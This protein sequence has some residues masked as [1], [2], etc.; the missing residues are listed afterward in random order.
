MPAVSGQGLGGWVLAPRLLPTLSTL[1]AAIES[2]AKH[3]KTRE[4]RGTMMVGDETAAS[5][6]R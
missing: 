3:A 5:P 4:N 2:P 6:S 1:E